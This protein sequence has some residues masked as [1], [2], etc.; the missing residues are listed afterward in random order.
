MPEFTRTSN[1]TCHQLKMATMKRVS[2]KIYDT[3]YKDTNSNDS[4]STGKK[5]NV[6]ANKRV[7]K[8]FVAID[9]LILND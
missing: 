8:M 5:M 4:K 7:S 2:N 3:N 9:D 1:E 6:S